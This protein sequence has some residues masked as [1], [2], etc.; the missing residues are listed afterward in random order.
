MFDV[1]SSTDN[2]TTWVAASVRRIG[3]G[4]YTAQLPQPTA[5]ETVSLRVA[6]TASGGSGIEQA[7]IQA[8]RAG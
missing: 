2:G 4:Q 1:W 5:G 3:S 8:Y 7:I 6:A